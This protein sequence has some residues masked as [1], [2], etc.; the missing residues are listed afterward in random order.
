MTQQFLQAKKMISQAQNILLAIHE[1]PDSD[2]IGSLLAMK[3]GLD[4]IGKQTTAFSISE[5]P[6]S[7]SF[8]PR[9][10]QIIHQVNLANFDLI[11][12]LDYGA[13]QRLGLGGENLN[14]LNFLTIDHHLVGEHLGFKIIDNKY[15]S[16]AEILYEFLPYLNVEV[17]NEI[18][19]C[20]LAG[21]YSDTGGFRHPNTTAQTLKIVGE[22]LLKGAPLQKIVKF[23]DDCNLTENLETWIEAFKNL[24]FDLKS[25]VIFSLVVPKNLTNVR[26]FSGSSIAS[27]LSNAPE[28]KLALLCIQKEP[29]IIECSLRSQKDRGVNVAKIAQLFGGGGHRL[30]AGFQT[31]TK[32]EEIINTIKNL[33]WENFSA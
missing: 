15:S 16:V 14:S 33:A 22:L 26:G 3:I 7:T 6:A 12:G 30:A 4:K 24:K 23:S 17:D 13:Y 25:G 5:I 9:Q 20:L 18:A 27:L 21:I 19:T 32:P 10:E 31:S 2:A 8:L 28:I 11:I 1:N 29:N